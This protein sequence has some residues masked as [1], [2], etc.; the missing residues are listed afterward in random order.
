MRTVERWDKVIRGIFI[1]Q[2]TPRIQ[3]DLLQIPDLPT[4]PGDVDSCFISGEPGAGK[5]IHACLLLLR[6]QRNLYLS[7]MTA[8]CEF[9]SVS[10]L[11]EKIKASFDTKEGLTE[12]QILEH[13]STV[14]LLI[15]D[16][17]G[18]LKCT[19]WVYQTLYLIIN[20]RYEQMKKTIIT[21]NLNL[22]QLASQ[23]GD[24]RITSRIERMC[25]IIHKKPWNG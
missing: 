19:D 6:E 9:I 11:I 14:H 22:E 15:L 7:E 5:T 20:N 8:D 12:H 18:T 24:D 23:L 16:D 17:F 13:Y 3:R 4:L 2:F 21:S 1:K 25:K 10:T